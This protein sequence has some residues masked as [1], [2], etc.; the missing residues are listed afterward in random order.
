MTVE[1]K[2]NEE[3]AATDG[4][5]T[6]NCADARHIIL[7]ADPSALRDRTDPVLR[8]HLEGCAECALAVSHVV[9]DLDRLRAA[10]IARGAR[11]TPIART[12]RSPKRVAMTLVP[13]ALA[14]ELALF[15]FLGAKDAPNPLSKQDIVIDDSVTSLL[16][17]A[18]SGV[19][20]GEVVE[21]AAP[22]PAV[23]PA[24]KPDSVS[25]K[26]T[27][28]KRAAVTPSLRVIPT[29]RQQFA[30]L[31]TSDPKVTVVWQLT[32]GDTL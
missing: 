13:V 29:A 8:A 17:V 21:I 24:R 1:R 28:A 7:G 15:A 3:G 12:R 26:D 14:A 30:V 20:T 2:R 16:P 6:V 4:R 23:I 10:L 27:A 32:K 9:S 19:D 25:R 22:A 11:V 18:P 31:T 5:R